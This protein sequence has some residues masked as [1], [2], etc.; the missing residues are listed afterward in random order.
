MYQLVLQSPNSLQ[1][2]GLSSSGK[3]AKRLIVDG[4][5]KIND[6]IIN[7]PSKTYYLDEI[8]KGIKT[9]CRKEETFNDKNL[10]I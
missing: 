7:D 4:G 5:A 9:K 10:I 3:D 8:S 6:E 2:T 1:E